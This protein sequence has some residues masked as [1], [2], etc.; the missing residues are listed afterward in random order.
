MHKRCFA[1]A[2]ATFEGAAARHGLSAAEEDRKS[3]PESST[4]LMMSLVLLVAVELL[5]GGSCGRARSA[6]LPRPRCHSTVAG[7]RSTTRYFP[8]V[9]SQMT[10]LSPP[11]HCQMKP[12]PLPYAGAIC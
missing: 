7:V 3:P 5:D 6:G 4:R 8:A 1:A 9:C 12:K 11:R 2:L 10:R